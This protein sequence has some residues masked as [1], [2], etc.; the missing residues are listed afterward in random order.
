MYD[1]LINKK[2]AIEKVNH[3]QGEFSL[4]SKCG[5]VEV[6]EQTFKPDNT[7][8]LYAT[9]NPDAHEIYYILEG[10]MTGFIKG[11]NVELG[12]GDTFQISQLNEEL[13]F[14]TKI[15]VRLLCIT[16]HPTFHHL[17]DEIN[18][19][20]KI[21]KKIEEKD[22]YTKDHSIRVQDWS[23][24]I[25]VE[26]GVPLVKVE[27]L[28]LAALFHDVGKIDIPE[29]ILK[30]P[31]KLSSDEYDLIKKHPEMGKQM[32]VG[33]ILEEVAMFIN[34][35]HERI[36][37]SG[38]PNGLKSNEISLES[39]IIAVADVYDAMTTERSYRAGLSSDIALKELVDY[40]NVRYDATVV[41]ALKKILVREQHHIAIS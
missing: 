6:I 8:C 31:G 32:V 16:T 7:L 26:L 21:V 23:Y 14:N 38:Y 19:L 41:N 35:H 27:V 12:V 2:K 29:T 24:K 4:L 22:P 3:P 9:E 30:K 28:C 11:D 17:S 13:Y 10:S 37:G 5:P 18:E 36:D 34:D 39:R 25:A 33:T 1:Y 20:H 15:G 40:S